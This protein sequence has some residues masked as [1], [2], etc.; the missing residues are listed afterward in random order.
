MRKLTAVLALILLMMSAFAAWF[1]MGGT[2]RCHVAIQTAP[3]ADYPEAFGAI[4]ALLSEG[5]APQVFADTLPGADPAPYTLAD[6]TLTLNNRG[7]FPA[8]WLH[9]HAS[10]APGDIAV[11]AVAGEA[12]DIAPR[13][14]ARVNLKLITTA[15]ADAVRD[16]TIQYYVHGLKRAITVR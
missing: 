5:S 4:R 6:I 10:A 3:A 13:D 12:E 16:I 7:L 11:Y 8:E 14:S 9:V 15:P 1:Y 2:L